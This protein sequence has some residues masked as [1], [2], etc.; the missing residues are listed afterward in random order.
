M[1]GFLHTYHHDKASQDDYTVP[2]RARHIP[3][4]NTTQD[5][6]QQ[7]PATV[8]SR[9][10]YSVVVTISSLSVRSNQ[11]C[12]ALKLA[13]ALAW[14]LPPVPFSSAPR[15]ISFV[16]ASSLNAKTSSLAPLQQQ[17]V[18]LLTLQLR[19]GQCS[20]GKNVPMQR[21]TRLIMGY[22]SDWRRRRRPRT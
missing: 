9:L 4:H 1:E 6:R 18:N 3:G 8:R 10:A 16:S 21:S 14:G 13:L 19:H 22:I 12:R 17:R 2:Y 15:V 20:G 5:K 7:T 11:F